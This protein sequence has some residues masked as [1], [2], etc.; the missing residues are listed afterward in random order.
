MN[1]DAHAR[2]QALTLANEVDHGGRY[3]ID[4]PGAGLLAKEFLAL[5]AELAAVT[6][7]RN[8]ALGCLHVIDHEA[9]LIEQW[10]DDTAFDVAAAVAKIRKE[11]LR[12][13]EALAA[14]VLSARPTEETRPY[15]WTPPS[16][17]DER[18]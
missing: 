17:P 6:K 2:V 8:E 13:H 1:P 16:I 15:D 12:A 7:A 10:G 18:G 4:S 3:S 5:A 9:H 14:T 11:R